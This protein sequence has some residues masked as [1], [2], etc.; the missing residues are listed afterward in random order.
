VKLTT[1]LRLDSTPRVALV[2]SGGKTTGLSPL[3]IVQM[4]E[5]AD[6][7]HAP[8]FIEADGASG[9]PLKAPAAHEPLI[10]DFMDTAIVVAGLS[11]VRRPLDHLGLKPH[12]SKIALAVSREHILHI[13]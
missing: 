13:R 8:L 3:A 2:G 1:A 11:G 9:L 5:L 7:Q 10:P 12:F 4:H 6:Q